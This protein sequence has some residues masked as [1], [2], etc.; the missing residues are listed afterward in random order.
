VYYIARITVGSGDRAGGG[1]ASPEELEALA[2][3]CA[4]TRSIEAGDSAVR[5]AHETVK[6]KARV[7]VV[8]RDHP[9]RVDAKR[10]GAEWPGTAPG[11]SKLVMAPSGAR[12]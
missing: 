10:Y 7:S 11:A 3:T 5:G 6:H 4:R 2:G 1:D 9:R 8:S 12:T